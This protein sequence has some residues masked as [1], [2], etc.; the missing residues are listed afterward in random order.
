MG[1]VY[2]YLLLISKYIE[3]NAACIKKGIVG[4][5]EGYGGI[6]RIAVDGNCD[7]KWFTLLFDL[8][9][10]T[11]T[12][13]RKDDFKKAINNDNFSKMSKECQLVIKEYEKKFYRTA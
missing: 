4:S 13:P 3:K 6:L 8:C 10:K 9:D 5:Y 11:D 12:P 7:L 1:G 2:D